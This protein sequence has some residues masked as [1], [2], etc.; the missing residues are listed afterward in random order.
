MNDDTCR[1]GLLRKCCDLISKWGRDQGGSAAILFAFSLLPTIGIVGLGIDYYT[2]LSHKTRLDAAAD[3]AAIAA[4]TTA[5]NYISA[6]SASQTDPALTNNAMAAGTAQAKKVFPVNAGGTLNEVPTTPTVSLTRTGQTITAK[7][8]YSGQ[9]ATTF[10]KLFGVP[11]FSISGSSGSSLTMGTYL[12]FYLALDVSGSMGLPTSDAGQSALAA[13]N[14]DNRKD[15]PKGCVFACHFPGNQG[16][17][18]AQSNN[19]KLRVNSVG[20]AVKTLIQTATSTKTLTNQYRIGVYPFIDDVMEAAPLSAS[21][22]NAT[23]AAGSLGSTYLNSGL[24]NSATTSMGSGGTHFENLFPDMDNYLK[25]IGDGSSS[26][27]PKVFLFIV[28]DGADNNQVYSA[29]GKWTG[30]QPS[31]PTNFGYCGQEKQR[32]VT[33]SILYIPYVPIQNPTSFAG[34]EDFKV[35]AIIPDIPPNLQ[36]CAT[37]GFFFTASSDADINAAMQAMFAQ[38]LQAA[39]LT[40]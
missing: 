18:L 1:R 7:V 13:I 30:S 16:Y 12:D 3:S 23:S 36:A 8:T 32:G 10:G 9:M 38:A 40:N 4:I 5:Q 25:V 11:H 31:A 29:N 26:T 21:F 39:R 27:K 34:N 37:P 24:S 19:I 2:G 28:T 35:N 14:P 6:N 17:N 15:Y 20:S 33:I 22:T